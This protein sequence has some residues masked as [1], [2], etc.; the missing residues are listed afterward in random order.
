[1]CRA[2]FFLYSNFFSEGEGSGEGESKL[3]LYVFHYNN[4]FNVINI[5]NAKTI[6]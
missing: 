5:Y 2:I 1:M 6:S 4:N 3:G